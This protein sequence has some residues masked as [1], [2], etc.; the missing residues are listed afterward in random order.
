MKNTSVTPS[1]TF[2][3]MPSP[4]QSMKMGART[5]RGSAF[6]HLDVG[7]EDGGEQRVA[8]EPE[9]ERDAG[10]GADEEGKD[11]LGEGNE[12]VLPDGLAEAGAE[13]L[14]RRVKSKGSWQ[15][16]ILAVPSANREQTRGGDVGG[17][18]EEELGQEIDAADGDGGADV[19]EEDGND[20]HEGL[21]EEELEAADDLPTAGTH[22]ASMP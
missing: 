5:T 12:E 11:A 9:A 8:G 6:S 7:V 18:G 3:Q 19:P 10:N 17:R 15:V 22:A 4:S 2:D 21:K 20:G 1:A 13:M 16:T 14:S